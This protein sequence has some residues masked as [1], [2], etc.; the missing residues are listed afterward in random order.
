MRTGIKKGCGRRCLLV[1]AL[2][3]CRMLDA[4]YGSGC[5]VEVI[6]PVSLVLSELAPR[7]FF[8]AVKAL[9]R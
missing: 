5:L 7:I 2:A 6:F 8:S 3:Q 4:T 1:V 9:C